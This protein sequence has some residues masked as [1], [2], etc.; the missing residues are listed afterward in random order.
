MFFGPKAHL[1]FPRCFAGPRDCGVPFDKTELE[2][3]GIFAEADPKH[4]P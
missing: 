1:D 4:L 2:L 3:A